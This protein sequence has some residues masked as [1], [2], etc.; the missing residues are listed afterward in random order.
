MSMSW[1][2]RGAIYNQGV[3]LNEKQVCCVASRILSILTSPKSGSVTF[4]K[5]TGSIFRGAALYKAPN[6]L[7]LRQLLQFHS[8][9]GSINKKTDEALVLG[10]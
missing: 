3:D 6:S 9:T 2:S 8:Q 4:D 1:S 5:V 10:R 7:H